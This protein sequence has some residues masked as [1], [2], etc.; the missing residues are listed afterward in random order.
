VPPGAALVCFAKGHRFADR[1]PWVLP[2]GQNT[3]SIHLI[4]L[5][6]GLGGTSQARE[7]LLGVRERRTFG[8]PFR[9]PACHGAG[10]AGEAG[11]GRG[12]RPVASRSRSRT[13]RTRFVQAGWKPKPPCCISSRAR[14]RLQPC[15]TIRYTAVI[16]PVR[17]APYWQCTNTG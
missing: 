7:R 14:S 15:A 1:L 2:W 6:R 9:P 11:A 13:K 12:A 4:I 10:A 5:D 8:A 17:S 16:M 3:R